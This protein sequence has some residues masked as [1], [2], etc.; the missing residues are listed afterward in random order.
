MPITQPDRLSEDPTDRLHQRWRTALAAVGLAVAEYDPATGLVSLDERC[1]A[2]LGL[3]RGI[4][5]LRQ[6]EWLE[7]FDDSDQLALDAAMGADLQGE[8]TERVLVRPRR[9][10]EGRQSCL[11]AA[12]RCVPGTNRVVIVLRDVTSEMSQQEMRR[13]TLAAERASQAKT[14]F[15]AQV[16]H[17]LRTPLN[18]ILG[19]AQMMAADSNHPM[20]PAQRERLEVLQHSGTR[21]LGLIDQ[22]LQI[23]RIESGERTLGLVPVSAHDAV[24]RCVKELLPMAMERD[25]AVELDLDPT[26]SSAILADP[27]ALA[28]VL[29]NL[30]SN[31]IKYNRQSGRVRIR[32]RA[33]EEGE[34]TVDDTGAGMTDSE[35]GHLFEPFNRLGAAK[36]KVHGTGLGL[37]ITR[38]LVQAMG[39]RLEV[40]SEQGRGSRFKVH[41]PLARISSVPSHPSVDAGMP[42]RW[43]TGE[44]ACVLYIEDD[45]VNALLMEQIFDTQ[46]D[47]ELVVEPTGER[48]I[49]SAI[50]RLPA[51]I[52]LDMNLPDKSGAEI[53]MA[54]KAHPGT[55]DI[56]CVAVS[57][58]ALPDHVQRALDL[59]AAA[60]WTKPLDLRKTVGMLKTLL[61]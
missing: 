34:L 36:T 58:D 51:L 43:D 35:L 54:L 19:F 4:G 47:W 44:R 41:L 55:R 31:A 57:A 15:M 33:E 30:V 53:L 6:P 1:Q 13:Q 40:W 45:E 56:P 61:A 59:G 3:G 17:E 42:S 11:D 12:M 52:L 25:V 32:F 24:T 23:G 49:A 27:A 18:A 48:G 9:L 28:Q 22:L 14:E 39:G 16:S 7:L 29:S 60:Y 2:Q 26:T 5:T 8:A 50:Q 38:E 21:L 20:H 10:I 37:V 46:P